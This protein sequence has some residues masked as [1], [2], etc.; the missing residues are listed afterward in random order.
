MANVP[1]HQPLPIA[2]PPQN[3]HYGTATMPQQPANPPTSHDLASASRFRHEVTMCRARGEANVTEDS[4][5]ESMKYER[6]LLNLA[7]TPQWAMNILQRIDK[8]V[9]K[10][11]RIVATQHNYNVGAQA[12][13]FE[14]VPFVDGTWPWNEFVDGPNNQQVQLP[15]LRSENDIRQLTLAQAYAYFRGY[16]PGQHMPVEG[17]ALNTRISAIFVEIGRGDLA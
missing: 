10:T 1:P 4:I 11:S 9:T 12:G 3:V 17:N 15:P 8:G 7:Q 2:L 6:R 16:R 5:A 14:E 13:L